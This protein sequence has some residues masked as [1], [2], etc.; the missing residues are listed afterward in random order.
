MENVGNR[1]RDG[2]AGEG[3]LGMIPPSAGSSGKSRCL[4]SSSPGSSKL[5]TNPSSWPSGRSAAAGWRRGPR[6]D[7]WR[8]P[9]T[10]NKQNLSWQ[11]P[12]SGIPG[13]WLKTAAWIWL[14][15][16][17]RGVVPELGRN[18]HGGGHRAIDRWYQPRFA[19]RGPGWS[20]SGCAPLW[21]WAGDCGGLP[22]I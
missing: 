11:V 5:R 21:R 10:P 15:S 3:G 12:G 13:S 22:K 7:T 2:H 20:R 19:F 4:S 1:R 14:V 18:A 8:S 17:W 16:N 6:S 9:G